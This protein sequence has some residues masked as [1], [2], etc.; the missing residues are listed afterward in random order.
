MSDSVTS[1]GATPDST[2]GQGQSPKPS[3][4]VADKLASDGDVSTPPDP[5]DMRLI[6]EDDHAGGPLIY[7]T[8]D[9]RTGAVVQKLPG[10]QVLRMGETKTYVAGQVIKT[11]V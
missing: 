3:P 4:E 6:I 9:R 2:Y 8:V 11:R 7:T 5:A 1:L 10:E